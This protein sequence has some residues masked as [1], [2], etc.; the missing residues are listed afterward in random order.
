[1]GSGRPNQSPIHLVN[2]EYDFYMGATEVTLGEYYYCVK[3]VYCR[4]PKADRYFKKMCL[5]ND[6]PVQ[7]ISWYDAKDY[8]VWLSGKT[9]HFY[10]LP[11]EAEWEY[12]VRAG[13]DTKWFFGDDQLQA[14]KYAWA[15]SNSEAKI[16]P[17]GLLEPNPWGLYDV[18]GNVAEWCEDWYT[19]SYKNTPSDGS[20]NM[21]GEQERRIYRSSGY[22]SVPFTSTTRF[23]MAPNLKSTY[24]GFRIVRIK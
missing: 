6:C 18:Y 19:K 14:Y 21:S 2:I 10:R 13:T 12:A 23:S 22:G 5:E 24:H 8:T 20:A 15:Y 1:M 3:D 9:G 4:K 16:H 7:N 11:T 17:V